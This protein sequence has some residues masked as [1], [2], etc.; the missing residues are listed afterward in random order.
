MG[1]QRLDRESHILELSALLNEVSSR[2]FLPQA[3]THN[4][5]LWRRVLHD[6]KISLNHK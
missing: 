5:I 1:R 4:T 2:S 3:I 6:G